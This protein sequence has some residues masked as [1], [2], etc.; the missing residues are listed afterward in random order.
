MIFTLIEKVKS[1]MSYNNYIS[2]YVGIINTKIPNDDIKCLSQIEYENE[3]IGRMVIITIIKYIENDNNNLK[4][5]LRD[6]MLLAITYRSEILTKKI[7]KISI[8]FYPISFDFNYSKYDTKYKYMITKLLL[9]HVGLELNV[10]ENNKS[11]NK[12]IIILLFNNNN[13]TLINT[14]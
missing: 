7:M 6:L 1:L 13:K 2:N 3:E 14:L 11:I 5:L 10:N 12:D 9:K 8:D 4:H